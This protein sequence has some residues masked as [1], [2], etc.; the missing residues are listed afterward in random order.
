MYFE[1]SHRQEFHKTSVQ[2]VKFGWKF[3]LFLGKNEKIA[4]GLT[5][6]FVIF[7]HMSSGYPYLF[8]KELA[9]PGNSICSIA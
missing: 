3:D 1:S 2:R 8:G 4:P 7:L 5:D 6:L 9:A